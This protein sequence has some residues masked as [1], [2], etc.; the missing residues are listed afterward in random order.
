MPPMLSYFYFPTLH[1]IRFFIV[2]VCLS[3][4]HD[5]SVADKKRNMICHQFWSSVVGFFEIYCVGRM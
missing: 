3:P 1:S 5:E 4:S 2:G